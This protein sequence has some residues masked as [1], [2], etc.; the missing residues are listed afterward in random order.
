MILKRQ[1]KDNVIKAIYSSSN[2]LASTYDKNKN[3]LTLIFNKG[4]QYKY[5]G[6]STTDYT[7]FEIAESQGVV[8]NTHIKK[9]EFQKLENIDPA[10]IIK[11]IDAMKVAEQNALIKGKQQAIV[12]RMKSL[13]L[14]DDGLGTNLFTETQLEGLIEDIKNY[15]SEYNKK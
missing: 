5:P 2:I 6:V 1:E 12:Q 7:R 4:S 3:D 15:V 13:I 8:F 14:I 9:Y 11:E 10:I